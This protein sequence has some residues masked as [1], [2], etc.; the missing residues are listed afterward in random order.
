MGNLDWKEW[1]DRYNEKYNELNV[2]GFTQSPMTLMGTYAQL[3]S[4]AGIKALPTWVDVDSPGYETTLRQFSGETG[5]IPTAKAFYRIN[6]K[7]LKE[8]LRI[9]QQVGQG[10]FNSSLQETLFNLFDE[11]TENLIGG[12]RNALT[13]M[14]HQ[15]VSTGKFVLSADN[16]P[17]GIKNLELTYGI[18]DSHFDDITKNGNKVAETAWWKTG[19]H[20]PSNEGTASDPLMYLKNKVKE[21]RRT[22]HYSGALTMELTQDLWDDLAT[23]TAVLKRI[24]AMMF[25]A[26]EADATLIRNM[27]NMSEDAIKEQIRKFIKV[28]EIK[29]QDSY[30]VTNAPGVGE[31]GLPDII[32]TT[33]ENF[34]KENVVFRPS[35]IIGDIQGVQPL[36]VGVEAQNIGWFDGGRLLMTQRP[37]AK[38]RSIYFDSEFAQLPVLN[39]PQYHFISKV[40]I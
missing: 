22:Y 8:R 20:I 3:I 36:T 40:T 31:D 30:A 12:Y 19:N 33:I 27:Q 35:G 28:D 11:G 25:P 4:S 32:P 14:R 13:H 17:R 18:A 21:I 5:E 29:T 34:K 9:I 24:G 39:M 16:N 1:V 10:A 23:H 37:E 2:D 26:I 15:V 7:I 6:N 38:T